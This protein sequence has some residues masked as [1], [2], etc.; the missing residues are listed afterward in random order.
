VGLKGNGL[1][2]HLIGP[3]FTDFLGNGMTIALRNHQNLA[4]IS[5]IFAS[6]LQAR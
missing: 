2:I 6:I 3:Y 1:Q 4:S 5:R